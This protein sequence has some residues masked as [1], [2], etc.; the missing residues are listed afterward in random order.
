[1]YIAYKGKQGGNNMSV[2]AA[3][4][5]DNRIVMAADSILVKGWSKS[6]NGNFA[7][8]NQINGMIVGGTGNAKEL[9]LLWHFMRTHKPA[10]NTEKE[11]LGYIV[12]FS[13]WKQDLIGEGGISNTYLLAYDGHLFEVEDMFVYEIKNYDAVGAG[14]DFANAALHLGHSPK[15]AVKVACELSCYVAEPII[16]Y[17][18]ETK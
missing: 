17:E 13:K 9:S 18:M 6:T 1:M 16:T 11:I 7:K 8:I 12:E 5:Y 10:G 15:E 4:V 2:V 14:E 3:K